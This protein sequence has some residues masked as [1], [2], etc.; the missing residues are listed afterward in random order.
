[1][2][3]APPSDSSSS[4]LDT[5]VSSCGKMVFL[6]KLL[7]KLLANSHRVLIFSQFVMYELSHT[8]THCISCV[9]F[10]YDV[11]TACLPACLPV[12]LSE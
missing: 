7:P 6:D 3:Q 8:H 10:L 5:L 2:S 4:M 11:A 12:R 9:T 1:M